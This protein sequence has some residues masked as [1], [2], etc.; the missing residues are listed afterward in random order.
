VAHCKIGRTACGGIC[1]SNEWPGSSRPCGGS[2]LRV[3]F[4][5]G[6][7][8][9]GPVCAVPFVRVPFVRVPFVRVPFVAVSATLP[10]RTIER[11]YLRIFIGPQARG[12]RAQGPCYHVH[13]AMQVNGHSLKR[14]IELKARFPDLALGHDIARAIGAALHDIEQQRDTYF[15]VPHGRLSC[16]S[17]GSLRQRHRLKSRRVHPRSPGPASSFGIIV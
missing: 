7:V 2:R 14:N 3:P 17:D 1:S 11:I 4:V 9:A 6:P 10:R 5:A 8:C 15:A 16:V 13:D 12:N